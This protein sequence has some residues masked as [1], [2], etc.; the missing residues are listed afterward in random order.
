M[1]LYK[2]AWESGKSFP[3]LVVG[4]I[5]LSFGLI[6][7]LN[8]MGAIS[9]ELPFEPAGKVLAVLLALSGAFLLFS[10][11]KEI[12]DPSFGPLFGWIAII[13]GLAVAGAGLTSLGLISLAFL[14]FIISIPSNILF[15]IMGFL[16]IIISFIF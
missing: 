8:N 5:V 2:K 15:T 12:M 16:L 11:V 3:T 6:P 10:G 7:L 1:K 14:T 4:L 13:L 9:F